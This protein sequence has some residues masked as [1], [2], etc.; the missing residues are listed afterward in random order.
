MYK[1][2]EMSLLPDPVINDED[3]MDEWVLQEVDILN[4]TLEAFHVKAEVTNWTI[5]PTVTQFEVTLNRG[6]KV[7]KITNLTDDLKLALAAKDIRI[8]APIPGKR[9]VGIEIPNKK[10]RPV[11]LSEVLNSKV[12]KEATSPLTVALGVDLFGQPQVTNIAKMP[13]G[14]IAGQ[15]VQENQYLSIV[16]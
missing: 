2:P 3:E 13:H 10:S 6:V 14:L 4:E 16:C 9:S 11:M 15:Q 5:G 8:E 7:N 12:F 1:F